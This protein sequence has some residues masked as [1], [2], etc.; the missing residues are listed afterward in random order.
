MDMLAV[1]IPGTLARADTLIGNGG[2]PKIILLILSKILQ[3]SIR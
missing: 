3:L 2:I 1:S